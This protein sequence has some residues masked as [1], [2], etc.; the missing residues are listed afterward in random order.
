MLV[1]VL[2]C[3]TLCPFYVCNN[4]DEEERAGCFAFIVLG[5]VTVSVMWLFLIILWA[6][7][8][9]VIVVFPVNTHFF[10]V[11]QV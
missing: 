2:V 10:I 9:C 3:I 11:Y 4:L 7:L 6:G 1:F 8:Q 5:I